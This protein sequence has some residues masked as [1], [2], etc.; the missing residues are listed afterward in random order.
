[1]TE[2]RVL[3]HPHG[4]GGDR[5]VLVGGDVPWS[6]GIGFRSEAMAEKARVSTLAEAFTLHHAERR[7]H[8]DPLGPNRG[9]VGW[10]LTYDLPL[11]E[12]EDVWLEPQR[13]AWRDVLLARRARA[14]G[15]ER[16]EGESADDFSKRLA[17]AGFDR[18]QEER[19]R[20]EKARRQ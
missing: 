7:L 10:K 19:A 9:C 16:V 12:R 1:M 3:P 8:D 17:R 4:Q 15:I 18:E 6:N 11:T 14:V 20:W 5:F 13:V 2:R